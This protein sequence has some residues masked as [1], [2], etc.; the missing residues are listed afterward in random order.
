MALLLVDRAAEI[1]ALLA[2]GGA[3]VLSGLLVE[4]VP[5]VRDAF[6][7][8]GTPALRVD[9]EWAAL[10]YEGEPM[11]LPRFHVPS[12]APGARVELPE[13]AAH[14]AREVLRL[15]A[16]A[17]VR[18]FDGVG[19]EFE[20]VLDEVSRR[21]VSAR[22]RHPV[23]PR[24]ESPAPPRPRRVAPEGRP[25]GAR[26]A[27]GDGARGGGDLAR[28][29]LPHRRRR[30]AGPARLPRRAVGEGGVGRGR[31][32]RPRGG[33]SR[34]ADHDPR[35]PARPPLRRRAGR[36]ARDARPPGPRLAPRRRRPHRCCCS[37]GRPAASRPPRPKRSAPP[38]S[39]P[40]PSAP[41]S[42]GPRPRPW[43]PWRSPRPR[44]ATSGPDGGRPALTPS[45]E[46]SSRLQRRDHGHV[47]EVLDGAA[48]R[49]VV[50][51]LVQALEDGAD[52]PRPAEALA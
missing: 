49:D 33:P 12:A 51:R 50:R 7:A 37:W 17:A 22:L 46:P 4:D 45:T 31:A 23:A 27:E 29:H 9:G 40:P 47:G 35:R 5:Y 3:L 8:C 14:H 41:A 26:G 52:R 21:T 10:L 42:C 34:P 2:P 19:A 48:P 11:T 28:R 25:D 24:P 20:A 16:G 6:A 44:G 36:A 43:P 32:V 13:H 30:A 1:R 39:P 38:A 15:R 18:V